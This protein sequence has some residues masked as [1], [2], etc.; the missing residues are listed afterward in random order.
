MKKINFKTLKTR[1]SEYHTVNVDLEHN[2]VCILPS[3][4]NL[5]MDS[6]FYLTWYD[7]SDIDNKELLVM[8]QAVDTFIAKLSEIQ[9]GCENQI[10]KDTLEV[11]KELFTQAKNCNGILTGT[12][13]NIIDQQNEIIP[14]MRFKFK[15]LLQEDVDKFKKSLGKV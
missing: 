7:I 9:E 11:Y 8:K 14:F 12:K 6:E 1:V 4:F 13:Y 3:D 10:H 2:D 5:D 15:F